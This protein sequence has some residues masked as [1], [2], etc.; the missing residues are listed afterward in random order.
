MTDIERFRRR[1][2][3]RVSARFDGGFI[4]YVFGWLRGNGVDTKGMS[5]DEAIALFNEKR[6][7][8]AEGSVP[9]AKVVKPKEVKVRQFIGALKQAKKMTDPEDA[10]RVSLATQKEYDEDHP[11]AKFYT[12]K[13]GATVAV[14]REGDII[15]ACAIA[16]KKGGETRGKQILDFAVKHGGKKLDS[17]S[18]NHGFYVR[19]GFEPISW[20]EWDDEYKPGDWNESRDNR[21]PVIFY[22]YVGKGNVKATENWRDFVDSV[23]P[24]KDYGAAKA[25][26]DRRVR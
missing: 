17:Y 5:T 24:S 23:K 13:D 11:G 22:K 21:E 3:K 10:W 1:R 20:C 8:G 18:G 14:D 16:G 9:K 25:E 2:A 4:T 6:S 7:E 19:C 12:A 15:S 26:R